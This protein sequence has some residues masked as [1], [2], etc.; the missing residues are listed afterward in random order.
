MN[1]KQVEAFRMVML[2]GTVTGAAER[3]RISQPAV[4]RLLSLLEAKIGFRLFV[5][6]KQRLHPTQEALL[7]YREVERSFVGLEKLE[8]AALDLRNAAKGSLRMASI[9]IVG[10]A[11]LPRVIARYRQQHP[12]VAISMQTRS[13]VTV[14]D[15]IASSNYEI[16]F[17]GAML[18]Q[19]NIQSIP[20]AALPAVCIMSARHRLA[21]RPSIEAKDLEGEEFISLD[22]TDTNRLTID[23]AF[24]QANVR[25]RMMIEAPYAAAVA[26]MVSQGIG[27]SVV[28]PLTMLDLS[29][30]RIVARPFVPTIMF[31]FSL[32]Y[33]RDIPLSLAA[34]AFLAMLRE[35]IAGL[36]GAEVLLAPP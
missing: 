19:A 10:L 26:A 27:V 8:R 14:I 9:P 1:T 18:D 6:A 13:A 28:S 15:W 21:A 7:F 23:R 35:E 32:Y 22:P 12:D 20:Y 34:R 4:S 11:L 36:Y 33:R 29:A 16:G 25:R 2:T 3:L 17:A 30:D 31:G 24:Q 5:R